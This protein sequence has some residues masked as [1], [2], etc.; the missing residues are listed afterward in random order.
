MSIT[1]DDNAVNEFKFYDEMAIA[2]SNDIEEY[3]TILKAVEAMIEEKQRN[4]QDIKDKSIDL[5]TA[6]LEI[7]TSQDI[8]LHHPVRK[9]NYAGVDEESLSPG[10][11][12]ESEESVEEQSQMITPTIQVQM[13]RSA[14]QKKTAGKGK[15]NRT[16]K[17][18]KPA[19]RS[20]EITQDKHTDAIT[21]L[22]C[23]YHP[24]SPAIDQA[25]QLCSSC[26]W[27]LITNG[28]RGYD[29]Y[30]AVISFLKGETKVIPVLGQPMC[31][32]HP[33]V[34]A[35]NQK[36]GLCKACQ[37]K[38]KVIGVEDRHLT[39]KELKA[40]QNLSL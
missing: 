24:E 27:K 34:P 7:T 36:T 40:L 30:P 29:K 22:K 10:K 38:A 15:V 14:H 31:P 3:K 4:L 39:K 25:R 37:K 2:Y 32:V 17:P 1:L 20:R 16:D 12:I 33:A 21:G 5:I 13:P 6:S 26:K 28:L 9:F 23:L 18:K 35:Y 19:V 11:E 8:P